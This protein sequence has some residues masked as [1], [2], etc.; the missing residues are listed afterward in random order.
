MRPRILT[1]AAILTGIL[2]CAAL[3]SCGGTAAGDAP[4][5]APTLIEKH[6]EAQGAVKSLHMDATTNMT[7]SMDTASMSSVLGT[8]ELT[9]PFT[10]EMA[11]DSGRETAHGTT[12][13]TISFMGQSQKQNAEAYYDMKNAV[14][15][16]KA[17]GSSSWSKSESDVNISSMLDSTA[18]LSE[19]SLKKAEFSEEEDAYVLTLNAKDMGDVINELNSMDDLSSQGVELTDCTIKS[20]TAVYTFDKSTCLLRSVKLT[21]VDMTATGSVQG[22]DFEMGISMDADFAF[23]KYDELS[24]SD[25]EI[26]ESVTSSASAKA[27]PS[28]AEI[29]RAA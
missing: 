1:A 2:C 9:M 20:G 23:S 29:R 6:N 27:G 17:E 25:Y 22:V 28:P 19:E 11:L 24:P 15:Y 21:A 18:G 12:K 26:P 5:D 10:I 14:S 3:T 13:T 4:T 8:S 7:M 16:V